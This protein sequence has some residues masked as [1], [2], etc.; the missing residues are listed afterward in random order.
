MQYLAMTKSIRSAQ[1][2][3]AA[4]ETSTTQTE[5]KTGEKGSRDSTSKRP[6]KRTINGEAMDDKDKPRKRSKI[7]QSGK[8]NSR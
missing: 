3:N 2:V 8:L 4:Q 7:V 6:K 1:A 5:E